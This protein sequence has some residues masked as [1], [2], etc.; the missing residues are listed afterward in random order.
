MQEQQSCSIQ[1]EE[2]SLTCVNSNA[3]TSVEF[4]PFSVKLASLQNHS[5]KFPRPHL[6][7][8]GRL[9]KVFLPPG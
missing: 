7:A 5:N 8:R 6:S 9:I 2:V 1:L 3:F 4:L